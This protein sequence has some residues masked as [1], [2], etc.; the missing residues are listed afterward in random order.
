MHPGCAQGQGHVICALS[1]IL[2]MSYSVVDGLVQGMFL[3]RVLCKIVVSKYSVIFEN[4]KWYGGSKLQ[5]TTNRNMYTR[6]R[7]VPK[8]VLLN[9]STDHILFHIL[10]ICLSMNVFYSFIVILKFSLCALCK[11]LF[12]NTL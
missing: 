11:I 5:L 7:L 6:F 2:G 10:C 9:Y 3:S 1:W 12:V 4:I 8:S